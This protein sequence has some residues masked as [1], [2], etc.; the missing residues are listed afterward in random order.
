MHL[1]Y[2]SS[3][4]KCLSGARNIN[5]RLRLGT[6]TPTL[7]SYIVLSLFDTNSRSPS[8]LLLH[9]W[10]FVSFS[11]LLLS[12]FCRLM[13][14]SALCLVETTSVPFLCP[15]NTPTPCRLCS[16]ITSKVKRRFHWPHPTSAWACI[17]LF[18]PKF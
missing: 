4:L 9:A 17:E 12:V 8:L 18:F 1:H 16:P 13:M 15:S 14:H 7:D 2:K 5:H 3:L 10:F 11:S 6:S